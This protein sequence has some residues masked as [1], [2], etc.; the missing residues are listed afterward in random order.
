[1][2]YDIIFCCHGSSC[3][4]I[5]DSDV[6]LNQSFTSHQVSIWGPGSCLCYVFSFREP[7]SHSLPGRVYDRKRQSHQPSQLYMLSVLITMLRWREK[8]AKGASAISTGVLWPDICQGIILHVELQRNCGK[9]LGFVRFIK[10]WFMHSCCYL[11]NKD[12]VHTTKIG[13]ASVTSTTESL[14]FC[15]YWFCCR[16]VSAPLLFSR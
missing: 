15:L 10:E 9:S 13:F 1:M 16:A 14:F 3:S 12:I 6:N 8:P 5:H 7:V 2:H 11:K 4:D